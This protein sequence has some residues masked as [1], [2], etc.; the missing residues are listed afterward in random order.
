MV[1]FIPV[2]RTCSFPTLYLRQRLAEG[3]VDRTILQCWQLAAQSAGLLKINGFDPDSGLLML[4]DGT[5]STSNGFALPRASEFREVQGSGL[6]LTERWYRS[7]AVICFE[8]IKYFEKEVCIIRLSLISVIRAIEG[9]NYC[10]FQILTYRESTIL[11]QYV[12]ELHPGTPIIPLGNS[13]T[14][15]NE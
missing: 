9:A 4:D 8:A 6:A 2:T 3:S 5:Y 14:D 13:P 7:E 15:Q 12:G 10:S 1:L 11:S